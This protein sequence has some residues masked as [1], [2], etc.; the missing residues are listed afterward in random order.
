MPQ[1]LIFQK[2]II[3]NGLEHTFR[4]AVQEEFQRDKDLDLEHIVT[5]SGGMDSRMVLAYAADMGYSD[6]TTICFSQS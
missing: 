4:A 1:I 2:Q 3:L 5:L 6:I